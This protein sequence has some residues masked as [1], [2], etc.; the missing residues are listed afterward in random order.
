MASHQIAQGIAQLGRNG[1][2]TLVHMQPHEVA[3]LQALAKSQGTSLTI[4]PETG[5]PEAFSLGGFFRSILP[6]IAGYGAAAAF[7]QYALMA[8]IAAGA[9]TGAATNRRDPLMLSLIHI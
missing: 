1:D 9:A 6:T 8:G 3:G 2:S 5:L 7:P 4:N